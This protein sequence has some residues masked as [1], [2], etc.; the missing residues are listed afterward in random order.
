[1]NP[2]TVMFVV[3]AI[4]L[5]LSV[6]IAWSIGIPVA[7]YLAMTGMFSPTYIASTMFTACDTFPLMAIPLFVLA[8]N[9]MESGG[10]SKRL[11]NFADSLCGHFR[12]GLAVITVITCMFFGALSG[13]SAA[14]VVAIGTVMVPYMIKTGYSKGFAYALITAAGCLGVLIPPSIPLVIYGTATNTSIGDLFLG[15]FGSGIA[16]GVALII[17]A[18]VICRMRGYKGNGLKFSIRRVWSTFKASIGALM[19]PVIILGG[20]Y[21]GFFTPTEAAGIACLYGLLAGIFIYKELTW[22]KIVDGLMA[23][24]TMNA[25][26]LVIVGTAA[27]LARMMTVENIPAQISTMVQ[28]ATSSKIV[29]LLLI[30][31]VLIIAGCVMDASPTITILAPILYPIVAAYG[32]DPIHFGIMFITN[33]TIGYI[34]PPVGLNI[35]VAVG[36]GDI[37]LRELIRPLI[38]FF[39][40]MVAALMVVTFCPDVVLFIPRLFGYGG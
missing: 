28:S 37:Q 18:L 15:G 2:V 30:N 19:V 32:V 4:C 25:Q 14:T 24:V 6:P 33:T 39:C 40:A 8:G 27:C 35:F 11:I 29:V 16:V 21:G 5:I 38:P 17:C 20:I 23:S 31:V 1:M 13:S 36:M 9:L 10:L 34:T 26:L 3:F 22:K 12:G 7:I